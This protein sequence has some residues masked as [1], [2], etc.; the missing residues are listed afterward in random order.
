MASHHFL[1]PFDLPDLGLFNYNQWRQACIDAARSTYSASGGRFGGIGLLVTHA[2]YLNLAGHAFEPAK[3]PGLLP[4]T[5]SAA[6]RTTARE[7]FD[8]ERTAEAALTAAVFKSIPPP[9]RQNCAGFSAEWGTTKIDLPV[10]WAHVAQKYG[11]RGPS[12]VQ[13]FI[14]AK[15]TLMEARWS[16]GVDPDEVLATLRDAMHTCKRTGNDIPPVEQVNAAIE[17]F[18]GTA[19]PLHHTIAAFEEQA[20]S[21]GSSFRRFEDVPLLTDSDASPSPAS[22]SSSHSA[23]CPDTFEGLA[24]RLRKAAMRYN[25][26][27]GPTAADYAYASKATVQPTMSRA[28]APSPQRPRMDRRASPQGPPTAT[29]VNRPVMP[30]DWQPG[31]SKYCYTHGFETHNSFD[32]PN[33][34]PGHVYVCNG[35]TGPRQGGSEAGRR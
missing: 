13:Q 26:S 16:P 6:T 22:S 30:K 28:P 7:A 29:R 5:A 14:A 24:T 25:S 18:G 4:S 32:C 3:P 15:K 12:S 31:T 23:F 17:A 20:D 35:I 11:P 10:M 2:E 9:T 34:G 8:R 1:P 21:L 19:G 33:P 27:T